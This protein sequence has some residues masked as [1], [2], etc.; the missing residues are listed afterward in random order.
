MF[1]VTGVL[2]E[3]DGHEVA[4]HGFGALFATA[5]ALLWDRIAP[6]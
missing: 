5:P 2:R 3:A 6:S 1:A 4:V